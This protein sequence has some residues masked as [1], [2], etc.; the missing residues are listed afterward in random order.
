[1]ALTDYKGPANSNDLWRHLAGETITGVVRDYPRLYIVL[2]SGEALAIHQATGAFWPARSEEWRK[3]IAMRR[4]EI[5]AQLADLRDLA[6][7]ES[8]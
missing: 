2:S 4:A 5:E 3:V 7:A 8:Q 6:I 1:M